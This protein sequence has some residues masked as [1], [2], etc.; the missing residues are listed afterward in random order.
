MTGLERSADHR[1]RWDDGPWLPGIT[2][3]IG[4]VDKSGPLI[5]WAKGVTADAALADLEAL[6]AMVA[7][8]GT[9]VAKAYLVAHATAESDTAKDIGSQVHAAAEAVSRG[10]EAAAGRGAPAMAGRLPPLPR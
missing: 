10:L 8:K 4:K 3:V 1:Y 7:R 9:A 2:S 6:Q 5:S